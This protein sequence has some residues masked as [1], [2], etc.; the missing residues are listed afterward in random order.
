MRVG[1]GGGGGGQA[2]AAGARDDCGA[3][4]MWAWQ[5]GRV[6]KEHGARDGVCGVHPDFLLLFDSVANSI[7]S[8]QTYHNHTSKNKN[9]LQTCTSRYYSHELSG[10][11]V[12]QYPSPKAPNVCKFTVLQQLSFRQPYRLPHSYVQKQCSPTLQLFLTQ[13]RSPRPLLSPQP[14]RAPPESPGPAGS[15]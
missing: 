11:S 1:E 13:A 3:V 10:C 2:R 4:V 14:P 9:V 15:S 7:T 8:A 5:G 6:N 12:I